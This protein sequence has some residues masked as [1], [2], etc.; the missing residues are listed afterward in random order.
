MLAMFGLKSSFYAAHLTQLQRRETLLSAGRF[1]LAHNSHVV[2]F[3]SK[4]RQKVK[5]G[6]RNAQKVLETP[7][8]PNPIGCPLKKRPYVPKRLQ[9]SLTPSGDSSHALL[10]MNPIK[11]A[12][13][14]T[15]KC[16]YLRTCSYNHASPGQLV[17][18]GVHGGVPPLREQQARPL[19]SRSIPTSTFEATSSQM[20]PKS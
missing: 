16:F 15:R 5:R 1:I 9:Y 2:T 14:D 20:H 3:H 6:R 4:H 11:R 8:V 13:D 19:L 7:P 12:Y 10:N 17:I 18:R